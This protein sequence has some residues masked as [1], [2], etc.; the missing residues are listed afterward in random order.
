MYPSIIIAHNLCFSTCLG[1]LDKLNR[2]GVV[3]GGGEGGR[4]VG[5]GVR[6]GGEGGGLHVPVGLLRRLGDAQQLAVTPSGT[7]CVC[8]C[9][10]VCVCTCVCV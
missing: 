10:C 7:V 6:E 8:V 9:G 5:L 1:K 4:W 2:L 3:N